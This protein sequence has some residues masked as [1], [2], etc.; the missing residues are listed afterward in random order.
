MTRWLKRGLYASMG[1]IQQ[2]HR[3][4]SVR[5]NASRERNC[6]CGLLPIAMPGTVRRRRH[7]WLWFPQLS[8]RYLTVIMFGYRSAD[9]GCLRI[10]ACGANCIAAGPD[11]QS[12]FRRSSTFIPNAAFPA[13]NWLWTENQGFLVKSILRLS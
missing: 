9:V 11:C 6:L 1:Q 7:C 8:G 3:P 5:H 4:Q 13:K 2:K 10:V 12:P